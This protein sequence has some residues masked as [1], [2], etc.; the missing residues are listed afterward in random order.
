M[1]LHTL[2]PNSTHLMKTRILCSNSFHVH[3]LQT[4]PFLLPV[5]ELSFASTSQGV[6]ALLFAQSLD[7]VQKVARGDLHLHPA[8]VHIYF[9]MDCPVST[10]PAVR[11]DNGRAAI[12]F[13]RSIV[14]SHYPRFFR[15][16][17][18]P[19]NQSIRR[20]TLYILITAN[21]SVDPSYRY[22]HKQTS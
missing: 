11:S 15:P 16:F 5:Q 19:N 9:A 21:P 3:T 13:S 1:I 17:S 8:M 4:P 12:L 20:L 14:L 6:F 2:H 7:H 10:V 22:T 18:L